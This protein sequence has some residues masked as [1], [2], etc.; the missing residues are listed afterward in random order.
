MALCD[1]MSALSNGK[2]TGDFGHLSEYWN[3]D[4]IVLNELS[5]NLISSEIVNNNVV[6]NLLEEIPP[7][8][9][10]KEECIKLWQV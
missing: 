1:I 7:L 10:L 8:K 9:E 2:L 3:N 5:A 6:K 4:M